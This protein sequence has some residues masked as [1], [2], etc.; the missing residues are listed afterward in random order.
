[1]RDDLT[2]VDTTVDDYYQE[3]G[4]KLGSAG[5][6]PE[7]HGGGDVMLFSSGAGNAGFKGTLDNTKVFGL[8]KSAMGL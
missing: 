1:M 4:V 3:V 6:Y 7:T 5:A 8:V 2:S